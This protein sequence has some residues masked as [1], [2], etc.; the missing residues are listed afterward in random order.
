MTASIFEPVRKRSSIAEEISERILTLIKEKE[1]HPGE[2]LPPER[3][4]AVMLGVSR[5]SLR[6]ALRALAIMNIIEMRQGDGTYISALEPHQLFEHLEF[7][8]HLD[9]STLF[10]LFEARK[11]VEVGCVALAAERIDDEALEHLESIIARSEKM[12][13]DAEAFLEAD[14]ELHET[15]I[16]A[17]DNPMLARFMGSISQLGMVSR[18]VTG[19]SDRVRRN[20]IADHKAILAALRARDAD[21][22]RAAMLH[23]L[24][25]VEQSLTS[26]DEGP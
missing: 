20:S 24:E 6:E 25:N 2:K 4:L 16:R 26:Q 3:E 22:A 17:S 1:L 5:P 10:Q 18:R 19:T 14:L 9:K 12:V 15:I 8:F 13:G 23:H 7:I 11:I 21:A